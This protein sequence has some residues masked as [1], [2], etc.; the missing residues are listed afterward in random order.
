M[1]QLCA[2]GDPFVLE[3]TKLRQTKKSATIATRPSTIPQYPH[4]IS[5]S[6]A[7]DSRE[8]F[9]S[10]PSSR[11]AILPS[12]CLV[13][14]LGECF[15]FS[16]L[17]SQRESSKKNG[18][19]HEACDNQVAHWNIRPGRRL[20]GED[21][22]VYR[23]RLDGCQQGHAIRRCLAANGGHHE[24][25]QLLLLRGPDFFRP[26]LGLRHMYKSRAQLFLDCA[27]LPSIVLACVHNSASKS[28]LP[29]GC[30]LVIKTL[31]GGFGRA[32]HLFVVVRK[33]LFSRQ[34]STSNAARGEIHNRPSHDGLDAGHML[35]WDD[36]GLA[37]NGPEGTARE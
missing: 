29:C 30:E 21:R 19:E 11:H 18:H 16:G 13:F 2:L 17:S 24:T 20:S 9:P 37:H 7:C 14:H 23:K 5:H 36:C 3:Y 4:D 33:I 6:L 15:G 12:V 35:D 25:R 10:T 26:C 8:S 32:N 31:P 28:R 22:C 34:Y 1:L 27:G